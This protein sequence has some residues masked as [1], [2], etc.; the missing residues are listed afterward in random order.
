MDSL[1]DILK[2]YGAPDQPEVI[3]VRKYVA[4]RYDT[5]VSVAINGET[6]VITTPSAALAQTLRMQTRAI[7]AACNTEKRLVFRIG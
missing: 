6:L 7:Q 5:P 3:A 1:Q 2:A 4:E